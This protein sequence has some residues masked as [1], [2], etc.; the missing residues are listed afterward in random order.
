[1][2]QDSSQWPNGGGEDPIEDIPE[3]RSALSVTTYQTS[4]E[5]EILLRF[6]ILN[7]LLRVLAWC[8]RWRRTNIHAHDATL[9]PDEIDAALLR[10]LRVIQEIHFAPELAAARKSRPTP[11][12]SR[13]S[14][15]VPFIDDHGILRV[16]K[17]L[18]HAMLS[19]DERHPMIAPPDSWLTKLLIKSCHCRTLHSGAQLTLGLLRLRWW[20]PQGRAVVK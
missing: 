9:H 1:M 7:K 16:G 17:R 18:K 14:K 6:S 2:R 8:H 10:W 3:T 5:P 4:T 19:Y 13:L 11:H 12:R 20:I 15:L